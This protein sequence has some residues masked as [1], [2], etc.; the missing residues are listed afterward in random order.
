MHICLFQLRVSLQKSISL[1]RYSNLY[2]LPEMKHRLTYESTNRF[3]D[4]WSYAQALDVA[5]CWEELAQ[6]ALYHI[7]IELGTHVPLYAQQD[8][9]TH[10]FPLLSSSKPSSLRFFPLLA[11]RAYRHLKNVAMVYSLEQVQVLYVPPSDL[12]AKLKLKPH[13]LS[14]WRI[15]ISWWATWQCSWSSTTRPKTIS[16]PLL[17]PWPHSRYTHT[18]TTVICSWKFSA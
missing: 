4:A 10:C 17:T 14:T 6:A 12:E 11:I 2:Q 5:S 15:E 16:L 8:Y 1:R 9:Y 7:D 13:P 18:H 3:K